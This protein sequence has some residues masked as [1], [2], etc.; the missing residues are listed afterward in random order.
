MPT[1]LNAANE[2]AV[3]AFLDG[4]ISLP[5]IADI[6]RQIMESHVPLEADELEKIIQADSEARAGARGLLAEKVAPAGIAA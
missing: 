5:E 4:G 3:R 2:V 6:N 1:V